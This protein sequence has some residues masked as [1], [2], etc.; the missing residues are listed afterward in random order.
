MDKIE[1]VLK[2]IERYHLLTNGK[3]GIRHLDVAV[4]LKLAYKDVKTPL[5]M[6]FKQK[7]IKVRNGINSHLIFIV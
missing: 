2:E 7:K 4:N 6:L 1:L 5:N 3:C